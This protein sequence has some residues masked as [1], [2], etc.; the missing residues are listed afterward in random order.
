M[1]YHVISHLSDVDSP[2]PA[3]GISITTSLRKGSQDGAYFEPYVSKENNKIS[4]EKESDKSIESHKPKQLVKGHSADG[5]FSVKSS[6]L[7]SISSIEQ[8]SL[9]YSGKNKEYFDN[10]QVCYDPENISISPTP[11]ASKGR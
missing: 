1:K 11:L 7:Q 2:I 5:Q 10:L 9:Q 6:P 4:E 3:G 8:N